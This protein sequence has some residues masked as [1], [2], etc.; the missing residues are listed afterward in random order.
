MDSV[1]GYLDWEIIFPLRSPQKTLSCLTA[2]AMQIE[3]MAFEKFS[4]QHADAQLNVP[5][6]QTE[7]VSYFERLVEQSSQPSL[8]TFQ[9]EVYLLLNKN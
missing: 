5:Y 9:K 7:L 4:D 1:L 8:T 2:M 6:M 3:Q